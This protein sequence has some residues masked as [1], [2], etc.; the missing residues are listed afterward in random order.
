MVKPPLASRLLVRQAARARRLRRPRPAGTLAQRLGWLAATRPRPRRHDAGRRRAAR[1]PGRLRAVALSGAA[2][3]RRGLVRHHRGVTRSCRTRLSADA[4]GTPGRAGFAATKAPH[5][6]RRCSTRQRKDPR[7]SRRRSPPCRHV[8]S[9]TSSRPQH[10]PPRPASLWWPLAAAHDVA[11]AA[12]GLAAGAG[13]PARTA[14]YSTRARTRSRARNSCPGRC[15]RLAAHPLRGDRARPGRRCSRP[16]CAPSPA[17]S[18]ADHRPSLHS[19]SAS[20][21]ASICGVSSTSS[22]KPSGEPSAEVSCPGRRRWRSGRRRAGAARGFDRA[23]ARAT[24]RRASGTGA[25]RRHGPRA[26]RRCDR[27]SSST[28]MVVRMSAVSGAG[29]LLRDDGVVGALDAAAAARPG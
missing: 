2:G 20:P 7:R 21:D 9:R 27:S 14:R 6:L 3:A 8:R 23:C 4:G 26:P 19:S 25:S 12:R 17:S 16:R 28:T 13:A 5:G 24:G 11:A 18:K 1:T 15:G 10:W 22:S 29:H